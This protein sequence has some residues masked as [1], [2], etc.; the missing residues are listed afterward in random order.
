MM[1][2]QDHAVSPA[3]AVHWAA[4]L[5]M[6][7]LI[8]VAYPFFGVTS[9]AVRSLYPAFLHHQA[10]TAGD[11]EALVRLKNRLGVYLVVAGS[12]PL[13][14][15]GG[16]TMAATEAAGE[17]AAIIGCLCVGGILG[18]AVVYSFFRNLLTDLDALL[19]VVRRGPSRP[20]GSR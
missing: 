1:H 4:S 15:I 12:V 17:V 2:V 14:A 7:G 16:L 18:L 5:V 11:E 10:P 13:L 20:Q 3:D 19:R 6:S 9:F 8:A